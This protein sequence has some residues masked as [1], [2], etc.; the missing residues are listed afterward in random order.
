MMWAVLGDIEF[1]LA[2]HPTGQQERTSTDYA[3]HARIQGKPRLEFIGEGLDELT[4]ELLF[5]AALTD[6][7]AQIRRLQEA[8]RA[9]EPVPFVLGSGDYRGIYLLT[10]VD[11]TTRKTTDGGRLVAAM[12]S[13]TLRE[14]A[15]PYRKPLPAPRGLLGTVDLMPTARLGGTAALVATPTQRVL[16]AAK[17]AGNLLRAGL[18]AYGQARALRDNPAA[19]MS[20]AGRLIGWTERALEPLAGMQSAA[21]LLGDGADLVQLGAGLAGD[22]Q[23]ALAG[24]SPARLETIADQVDAAAAH[25]QQAATRMEAAAPRLAGLAAAVITRRA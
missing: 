3:E 1:E 2:N 9:H 24:M 21:Q 5:H 16:G 14:Y 15:G 19:L 11:T 23:S 17:T 20:Q 8:R 25:L 10:G 6:P 7:E 4:L 18:D 22:V 12:V 13:V